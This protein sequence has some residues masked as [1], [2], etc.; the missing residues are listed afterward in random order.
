MARVRAAN[1]NFTHNATSSKSSTSKVSSKRKSCFDDCH[2]IDQDS[3]WDLSGHCKIPL[4]DPREYMSEE[5]GQ[6]GTKHLTEADS[7]G[8]PLRAENRSHKQTDDSSNTTKENAS[9]KDKLRVKRQR[10]QS[11]VTV[12]LEERLSDLERVPD[13]IDELIDKAQ[14][15][16]P[17]KLHSLERERLYSFCNLLLSMGYR[18]TSDLSLQQL[19]IELH[20]Q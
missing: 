12:T 18:S 13:H 2:D 14:S 19:V 9:V 17:L 11:S 8:T 1:T 7:M 15:V 10:C 4:V 6:N 5:S 16:R 3:L 20:S